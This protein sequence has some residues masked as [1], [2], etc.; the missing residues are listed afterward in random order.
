MAH[1]VPAD[2]RSRPPPASETPLGP[3]AGP[4]TPI[5]PRRL[6]N[7]RDRS[8]GAPPE[9]GRAAP[10]PPP[11]RAAGRPL[12]PVRSG[13]GPN[14]HG[15]I[16][17]GRDAHLPNAAA[18]VDRRPVGPPADAQPPPGGADRRDAREPIPGRR[19]PDVL[20]P[21]PPAG[22]PTG[23]M[24]SGP[25][26]RPPTDAAR[27]L[28][29]S[30]RGGRQRPGGR[31]AADCPGS[32]TGRP[33]GDQLGLRRTCPLTPLLTPYGGAE[34]ARPGPL[35]PPRADAPG[36][37]PAAG[38]TLPRHSG[39]LADRLVPG[40][41]VATRRSLGPRG[42]RTSDHR[43]VRCGWVAAAGP[44]GDPDE[45]GE[46]P[47]DP[48]RRPNAHVRRR[49]R[50]PNGDPPGAA[51]PR[52][53]QASS[54]SRAGLPRR[55]DGPC[56]LGSAHQAR[57]RPAVAAG[58]CQRNPGGV[59]LSQG[60]SPQVPSALASLTAVFGMGTGVSSPPWP[61]EIVRSKTVVARR[62]R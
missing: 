12:A 44:W 33:L 22:P 7:R 40:W 45:P 53:D 24:S 41:D 46:I 17:P 13:P 51:R 48:D 31:S 25:R 8:A 36:C 42:R 56:R 58:L 52:R 62:P 16:D 9:A 18:P 30:I 15:P 38:P 54:D 2:R 57:Q 6:K 19:S 55:P 37:C 20:R 60:A 47:R 14:L 21:A 23:S 32:W 29:L 4:P 5:R 28:D 10:R 35:P 61:P 50:R 34:V 3:P 59:L 43:G 11:A 1:A 39:H 26:A 49:I 27:A